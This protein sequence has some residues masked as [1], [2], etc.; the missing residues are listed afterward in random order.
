MNAVTEES[1]A[2]IEFRLHW[3]SDD[4]AHEERFYKTVNI[5]RDILPPGMADRVLGKSPGERVEARYPVNESPLPFDPDDELTVK[6]NRFCSDDHGPNFGRFYPLGTIKD[7]PNVF[8]GNIKPFRLIAMDDTHITA[9]LNHPLAGRELH[10]TAVVHESI[11]KPY[12][13]G[14][15]YSILMETIADGPGMQVRGNGRPTDFFSDHPFKRE[16]ETGDTLFYQR[17][18]LVNHIDNRA[19][20]TISALYGSLIKP[21]MDVL[22]LM[23]AWRSHVPV[24]A[25]LKSLVGLG[26]NAEEMAAN[27]QLTDYMVHD[28]NVE[29]QLPFPDNSF[30]LV[31]CT[32][33]LEYLVHPADVFSGVAGVLRPGGVFIL[34]FSNRWFPPKVIRVWPLLHE[35]ERMGLVLEYFMQSGRFE[36]L[37]TFSSR[38]WPRPVE[39]KYYP[40]YATSDP[41]YAVWGRTKQNG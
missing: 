7:L 41:V 21:G 4:A 28:L 5:S 18:R 26:M 22:D 39:D 24:K 36:D 29:P 33:S 11:V 38:G 2:T 9:D 12:D 34:T 17:P 40:Q 31:I 23:S 19:I 16:D 32:V 30:D 25:G 10:L 14:G 37:K 8:P 6:R 27:P 15:E 20:D 13:R 3:N 1:L 35:F